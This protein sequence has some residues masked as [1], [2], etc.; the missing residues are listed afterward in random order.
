MKKVIVNINIEI[1]SNAKTDDEAIIEAENYELP[2]EY[3]EESFEVVKVIEEDDDS[4]EKCPNCG[5][6]VKNDK[7]YST[8]EDNSDPNNK[9]YCEECADEFNKITKKELQ[10]PF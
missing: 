3:V 2:K 6:M 5:R 4:M 7:I 8:H 9:E 10:A 1:P